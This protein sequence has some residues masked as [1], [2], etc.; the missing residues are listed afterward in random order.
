MIRRTLLLLF[1]AT[2]AVT[3][4]RAQTGPELQ[5]QGI[6]AYREL[7]MQAAARFLHLALAANDLPDSARLTTEAYLGAAEF[8]GSRPDSARAAF[9]RLVL[10]EPRFR[11]DSLLFPPAVRAM[12]D[13]VRYA[14]PAVSVDVPPRVTFEP[15]RGGLTAHVFPSGPHEVRVRIERSN[16]RVVRTLQD[17]Q[18]TDEFSVT[19]DGAGANG[20]NLA[21]G[22]YVWSFA[23]LD[24]DGAVRRVLDVPVRL[25]HSSVDPQGLPTKPELLPERNPAQPALV[26]LGVGVGVAALAWIVTPAFTDRDAPRIVMAVGFTTA[27]LIGFFEKMPGRPLPQNAAANE[28]ALRA[29]QAEVRR[30]RESD[31]ARRP[32]PRITLETARPSVRR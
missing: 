28:A 21:N 29:W 3:S 8:Y 1:V 23:S 5:T 13:Q 20:A 4:A 9:R 2:T 18:V 19:W 16:G 24:G 15:G 10:L 6:Q 31:Q 11:L 22:L 25:A 30:L 26:R 12:F 14:T 32:G 7:E 17:R 27:G